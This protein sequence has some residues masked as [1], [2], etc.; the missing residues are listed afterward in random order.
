MFFDF[1]LALHCEASQKG[2]YIMVPMDMHC[3]LKSSGHLEEV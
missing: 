3:L 1:L 2:E